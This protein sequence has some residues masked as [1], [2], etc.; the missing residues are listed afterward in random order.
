M[1]LYTL[2]NNAHV[3]I[4]NSNLFHLFSYGSEVLV[5]NPRDNGITVY[6]NTANYS[7]TTKKH[8]RMFCDK[9]LDDLSVVPAILDP[10]KNCKDYKI[11]HIINE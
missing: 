10:K 6:T 4:G 7:Q 3:V 9:F 8:V 11:L 2:N 5:Y 1:R